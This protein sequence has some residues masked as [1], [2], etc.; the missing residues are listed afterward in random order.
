MIPLPIL[1]A[2]LHPFSSAPPLNEGH[3]RRSIS[4]K[5]GG[6]GGM[7]GGEGGR[8]GRR[9]ADIVHHVGRCTRKRGRAGR[10]VSRKGRRERRRNR[11]HRQGGKLIVVVRGV[12]CPRR[13]AEGK[14]GGTE[15]GGGEHKGLVEGARGDARDVHLQI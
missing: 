13:G 4:V 5:V 9:D 11:T 1:P 8:V 6:E 14:E 10:H 7:V 3:V 2:S 15:G 12:R